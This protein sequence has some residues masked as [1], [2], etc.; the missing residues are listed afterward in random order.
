MEA[1]VKQVIFSMPSNKSPGPDGYTVEFFKGVSPIV[2]NDLTMAIQSFFMFGFLSTIIN[3]T[4]LALIP[5]KTDA[6]V[7]KD[8]MPIS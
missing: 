1:E 3:S 8:Y 7:M 2:G 5:K 4:T 6:R